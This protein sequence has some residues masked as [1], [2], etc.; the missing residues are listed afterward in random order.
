M[1]S[2]RQ[3]CAGD[4]RFHDLPFGTLGFDGS[5]VQSYYDQSYSSEAEAYHAPYLSSLINSAEASFRMTLASVLVGGLSY[6]VFP[7]WLSSKLSPARVAYGTMFLQSLRSMVPFYLDLF[8][9]S[10]RFSQLGEDEN[11]YVIQLIATVISGY[12]SLH[13]QRVYDFSEHRLFYRIV[14]LPEVSP[15]VTGKTAGESDV[16]Q[17]LTRVLRSKKVYLELDFPVP[18]GCHLSGFF[19]QSEADDIESK[20]LRMTVY[21]VNDRA[22]RQVVVDFHSSNGRFWLEDIITAYEQTRAYAKKHR[23]QSNLESDPVNGT[24]FITDN[25]DPEL[26]GEWTD[27][28]QFE[29]PLGPDWII[30]L[31]KWL[32][33]YDGKDENGVVVVDI[34]SEPCNAEECETDPYSSDWLIQPSEKSG[35][36]EVVMNGAV[37]YL[38]G[39]LINIEKP[40]S[41]RHYC[42]AVLETASAAPVA[43]AYSASNRMEAQKAFYYDHLYRALFVQ[44]S[45]IMAGKAVHMAGKRMPVSGEKSSGAPASGTVS[46]VLPVEPAAKITLAVDPVPRV[47]SRLPSVAA[48]QLMKPRKVFPYW[49]H[50]LKQ[51]SSFNL[52]TLVKAAITQRER[53]DL[54]VKPRVPIQKIA[55]LKK[56]Q[57]SQRNTE[58]A[59][60]ENVERIG[61]LYQQEPQPKPGV[62]E[63]QKVLELEAVND[64]NVISE[65]VL[66]LDQSMV[67]PDTVLTLAPTA[68]SEDADKVTSRDESEIKTLE[69]SGDAIAVIDPEHDDKKQMV[70]VVSVQPEYTV[71][72]AEFEAISNTVVENRVNEESLSDSDSSIEGRKPQP[73]REKLV[74]EYE[75]SGLE[76][77]GQYDQAGSAET[78]AKQTHK[79][80]LSSIDSSLETGDDSSVK[81]SVNSLNEIAA[82]PRTDIP[83]TKQTVIEDELETDVA[84]RLARIKQK[85]NVRPVLDEL[86]S[87]MRDIDSGIPWKEVVIERIRQNIWV[88]MYGAKR[89]NTADV[90]LPLFHSKD[91][92]KLQGLEPPESWKG[93]DRVIAERLKAIAFQKVESRKTSRFKDANEL[94]VTMR[95]LDGM[96]VLFNRVAVV[97]QAKMIGTTVYLL[98]LKDKGYISSDFEGFVSLQALQERLSDNPV[99]VWLHDTIEELVDEEYQRVIR[100]IN[101]LVVMYKK[102]YANDISDNE[103][104]LGH[105]PLEEIVAKRN[106]KASKAKFRLA[107]LEGMLYTYEHVT[108]LLVE[109]FPIVKTYEGWKN[110]FHAMKAMREGLELD[111]TPIQPYCVKAKKLL[112]KISQLNQ[113]NMPEYKWAEVIEAK[114]TLEKHCKK[115]GVSVERSVD[116]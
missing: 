66:T 57:F 31:T 81:G 68:G 89:S 86:A 27:D 4:Q 78:L 104:I 5:G 70:E 60:A 102:H 1:C 53:D 100:L 46:K 40:S 25:S 65:P 95:F 69:E 83:V 44:A 74:S 116:Y 106:S 87:A 8:S 84:A 108:P 21:P 28:V 75:D 37:Y 107:R 90:G 99:S 22:R 79:S 18:D 47:K 15:V 52:V 92:L 109:A 50:S 32:S 103:V 14:P 39:N 58:S 56:T 17:Q 29:S 64:E 24:D 33:H 72:K 54:M 93:I 11:R 114:D 63:T 62:K 112:E 96:N 105:R 49:L 55:P 48:L 77:S 12:P 94:P 34:N 20:T 61:S 67:G 42:H 23:T 36:L 82:I 19:C 7:N 98:P 30:I 97:D 59:A 85:S 101:D 73:E 111:P 6:A 43:G 51:K 3:S 80:S 113:Y 71:E 10:Y 16:V 45:M 41:D 13:I 35:C 2:N 110:S 38:P 76:H 88:A 9:R 91:V 115:C 26:T